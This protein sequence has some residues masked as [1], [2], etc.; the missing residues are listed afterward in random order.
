MIVLDPSS[1]LGYIALA[2]VYTYT[3]QTALAQDTLRH[4]A[5]TGQT[6][7]DKAAV[8][9]ALDQAAHFPQKSQ[10]DLGHY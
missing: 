7:P 3:G 10:S 9:E 2:K 5:E 6:Y 8:Q 4:A 1:F